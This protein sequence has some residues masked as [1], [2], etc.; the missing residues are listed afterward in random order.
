MTK[1]TQRKIETEVAV[2]G[3]GAAGCAAALALGRAGVSITLVE[4]G[5][6][7]RDRFCGEFISGEA[8]AAIEELGALDTVEALGPHPIARVRLLSREGRQ[9][10]LPLGARGWGLSRR[11][12]DGALLDKALARGVRLIEHSGV[13]DLSGDLRQGYRL[14][15]GG[16]A[17]GTEIRCRAVIGAHGKASQVDRLLGRPFVRQT[18]RY[19]GVK[20]RFEGVDRGN[21]VELYLFPG[22]YC[23]VAAIERG[24]TNVCLLARRE[25]LV[26]CGGRPMA[27]IEAVASENK[28]FGE[29]FPSGRPIE[30][31]LMSIG[32]VPFGPKRR[33]ERGVFMAGDSAGVLPPFL[34]VGVAAALGSGVRCGETVAAWLHGDLDAH[35]AAARYDAW[36]QSRLSKTARWGGWASELL[37]RPAV[38]AGAIRALQ[39]IPAAGRLFYSKTRTAPRHVWRVGSAGAERL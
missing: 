19:I 34:G 4:K 28:A 8:L 2:I 24:Q 26:A 27:V 20:C 12:L 23:G 17:S 10:E 14:R 35:E 33:V 16:A 32:Q 31:T 25:V 30:E 22:G 18:S 9:F 11:A 37:C 21:R 6:A 13:E 7:R 39:W 36:W 3:A 38:G 29:W 1:L 15:L 5:A